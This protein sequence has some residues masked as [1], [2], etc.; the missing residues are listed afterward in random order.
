MKRMPAAVAALP[1]VAQDVIKRQCGGDWSRVTVE[2]GVA[3][4]HNHP[5]TAVRPAVRSYRSL[6]LPGT[7]RKARKPPKAPVAPEPES[8][9][10]TPAVTERVPAPRLEPVRQ[11]PEGWTPIERVP[12]VPSRLLIRPDGT[13]TRTQQP[14]SPPRLAPDEAVRIT[15]VLQRRYANGLGHECPIEVYGDVEGLTGSG[16]D[17]ENAVSVARNARRCEVRPESR[18]KG[19]PILKFSVG[20]VDVIVGF[21]N[22]AVPCILR[23]DQNAMLQHDTHRVYS[24][25]GGGAKKQRGKHGTPSKPDKIREG[26]VSLG[27]TVPEFEGEKP[28]EVSYKSQSLGKLSPKPVSPDDGVRMWDRFYRQWDAINRRG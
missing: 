24:H 2:G 3:I 22:P 7:A 17:L 14:Y 13:V 28:V 1:K 19:Y 5:S 26:L 10:V 20:D 21:G 23:V 8:Q 4:V 16:I 9:P 25:G 6:D 15:Y 27:C 12:E 11:E 18:H